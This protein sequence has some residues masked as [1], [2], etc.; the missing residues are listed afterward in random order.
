MS[1]LD[2]GG[3]RLQHVRFRG[4]TQG[5]KQRRVA[6]AVPWGFQKRQDALLRGFAQRIHVGHH[7]AMGFL[8]AGIQ[9]RLHDVAQERSKDGPRL[10][11]LCRNQGHGVRIIRTIARVR[12]HKHIRVH[13][14]KQ[15]DK[16]L[17]VP[18]VHLDK[19]SIQIKVCRI[20]PEPV[21]FRTILVGSGAAIATGRPPDIVL[22]HN[23]PTRTSQRMSF[24]VRL[25]KPSLRQ[26][27]T[28]I[29][30]TGFPGV[31][32][33]VDQHAHHRVRLRFEPR[34]HALTL[35]GRFCRLPRQ[36]KCVNGPAHIAHPHL[37]QGGTRIGSRQ[38]CCH[39]HRFLP[40]GGVVGVKQ[41][42]HR[43]RHRGRRGLGPMG[44]SATGQGQNQNRAPCHEVVH[45]PCK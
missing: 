22:R 11:C 25:G 10:V 24:V 20:A 35:R 17:G 19:V 21:R 40:R 36:H 29:H 32:G 15:R 33:V 1:R 18:A 23:D 30:P 6:R 27:Q 41:A 42:V 5:A 43:P 13:V 34:I 31:N 45:H 9:R 44:G 14:V 4:E 39:V 3:E 37:M 2:A 12:V 16:R 26:G 8:H 38:G 28:G 7:G